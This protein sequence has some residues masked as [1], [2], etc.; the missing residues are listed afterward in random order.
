MAELKTKVNDASVTKFLD[1]IA[2]EKKRADGYAL[3]EM[4]QKATQ[5]EPKMWGSSIIGFGNYHY[6]YESGREGDWFLTGF[7]PRKQTLTLY[8]MGGGWE[9]YDALLQKLGKHSLGKGCLY[10][11]KL[12]D[13]DKPTLKKLIGEAVKVARKQAQEDAKKQKRKK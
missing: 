6:V 5:T 11:K 1:S 3:L 7:S 8:S 13:V 2:D 12:D 4:M 10:I 9:Q